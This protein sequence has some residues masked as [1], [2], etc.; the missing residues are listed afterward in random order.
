M[1]I[2][3]AKTLGLQVQWW[4]LLQKDFFYS[5]L[6]NLTVMKGKLT[7]LSIISLAR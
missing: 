6:S 2:V 4:T 1:V 3:G 7:V 5:T